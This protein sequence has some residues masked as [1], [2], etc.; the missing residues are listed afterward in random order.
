MKKFLV[1][2][3]FLFSAVNFN[4]SAH[5][6]CGSLSGGFGEEG[7]ALGLEFSIDEVNEDGRMPYLT[8]I[9]G[10][11]HSFLGGDLNFYTE[12]KYNFGFGHGHG[13]DHED[14]DHGHDHHDHEGSPQSI[15][16]NLML[17][18]KV[19]L[20]TESSLTFILQ[21][22]IDELVISPRSDESNNITGIFTSAINFNHEFDRGDLYAQIDL[23]VAYIQEDKDADAGIGLDFTLGWKSLLG[24]GLEATLLA[25]LSPEAGLDG[26]Q[27]AIGYE[28]EPLSFSVETLFPLS[29]FDHSGINIIPEISYRHGHFNFYLNCGFYHIGAESGH[30]HITPA[31]GFRYT[32]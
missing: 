9:A 28:A 20:G 30:L 8:G 21:H 25:S 14:H 27:F 23:P 26:L 29:N 11:G 3:I 7:V 17:G 18:Y 4:A 22:E 12:L 10:F 2:Y 19:G 5:S 32:F 13:H 24:L 31:L 6:G 1:L 16:F 15:Y